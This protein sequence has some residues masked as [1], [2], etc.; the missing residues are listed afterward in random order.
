MRTIQY[1]QVLNAAALLWLGTSE[2]SLEDS[3]ILMARINARAGE[4]W[5][6]FM[7][8]EWTVY[9]QRQ[10]RPSWDAGAA[11]AAGDQVYW[12]AQSAYYQALQTN[13]N[14]VPTDDA[15][16]VNPAC[17]ALCQGDYSGLNEYDPTV[18]Y[19]PGDQVTFLSSYYQCIAE[20]TG[21][22]PTTGYW[23]QLIE[24]VRL[25]AY[26]QPGQTPLGE[27]YKAWDM[28]PQVHPN[29]HEINKLITA[30][31]VIVWGTLPVVWLQIR[32]RAPFW[33]GPVW[34][35]KAVYGSGAAVYYN[36]DFYQALA[37]TLAGESPTTTPGKW[38]I[39]AM[40]Y[41]FR[42][43]VPQA[44]YAD[45]LRIDD[46][47]DKYTQELAEAMR[48]IRGEF[49]KIE[50]QQGQARTMNVGLRMSSI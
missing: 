28:N 14:V 36:G 24:F 37:A 17:W 32:R 18:T 25:V 42:N 16:D 49:D 20:S 21:N 6:R 1:S 30:A 41:V 12:P 27:V 43:A 15:G 34:N 50:R 47:Q 2:L 11:Y 3:G 7:W 10:F 9:E 39:L 4:L 8:P 23:G 45:M 19:E 33:I 31:G 26:E 40:P 13:T 29:A 5:E 35:A 22:D 44:V 46:Q 38:Q 48:L